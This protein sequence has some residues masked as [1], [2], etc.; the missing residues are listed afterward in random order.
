MELPIYL[1]GYMASG[2]TTVGKIL[3]NKLGW[4][5]V[6]LD[7]AFLEVNGYTTGEYIREFGME[8][9]R[10]KEK[11]CVEKLAELPIE[12]VIYATGGGYPCWED[13]MECLHELGT[14]FY[15]RW[16]PEQLTTRLF[17]SGITQRP[18]A[19]DGMNGEEGASEEE[20]MLHFVRK[21]LDLR[22]EYYEMADYIIDAPSLLAEDNDEVIAEQLYNI[23]RGAN[24]K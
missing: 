24:R 7:N 4:H 21:H 1:I 13:N 11:E 17:L 15:L 12:K 14:S 19:I 16:T 6:D 2:K 5:F 10:Q 23:I 20:K 9:F 3:A 22:K 8:E 18:V